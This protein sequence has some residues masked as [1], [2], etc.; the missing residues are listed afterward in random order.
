MNC[1]NI[2]GLLALSAAGLLDAAEARRVAEH[3]RECVACAAELES[4]GDVAGAL[5]GLPAPH[6]PAGLVYQT[7]LAVA[8]EADRR[9]G[10]RLA[11]ASGG[12]AWVI[13]LATWQVGG[14]LAGG[15][16]IWMWTFWCATAAGVGSLAVAT[17]VA[18]RARRSQL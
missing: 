7:Q 2:R 8:V 13:A 1:E 11:V 17:L 9:Q 14:M 5:G 18:Q 12:L 15:N 3:V 16:E 4:L 6:A 10:A